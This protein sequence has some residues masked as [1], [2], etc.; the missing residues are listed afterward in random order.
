[1]AI[2][3]VLYA[4]QTTVI[5]TSNTA[6]II[7]TQTASADETIPQD[8]VLVLGKLGGVARLQKDVASCKASFKCYLVDSFIS[9]DWANCD[10]QGDKTALGG[11]VGALG[12][13]AG[14]LN[15]LEQDARAGN[16]LNHYC[17]ST[18]VAGTSANQNDG[19]QIFGICSSMGIDA[20]K[21]AFPMLDLA[22][23]GVGRLEQLNMGTGGTLSATSGGKCAIKTA[24][25][26]TS[27][28]VYLGSIIGHATTGDTVA[29]VKWSYDMPTE[30]LSRLG[31]TI[32]GQSSQIKNDN[33]VFS[34]P[35][36][37]ASMVADGQS[38]VKTP[39]EWANSGADVT[40]GAFMILEKGG[41]NA[42]TNNG[43]KVKLED[44]GT[45]VSTRSLSQ[46]VGDVGATFSVTAE[47]TKT[48][49]TVT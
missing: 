41:E 33:K 49:F 12:T 47:G 15:M 8:D 39:G 21:G 43:C 25:P 23:E 36:F 2:N 14:M 32:L 5:Q 13:S 35:P 18:G 31:G 24:V 26:L 44:A 46:N 48:L 37:K 4:T 16:V 3:R 29:S 34:K 10:V 27:K 6:W 42:S 30:T 9:E 22:F 45:N 7:P 19:F 1:M 11:N 20:S 38:L 28:D 40:K 17:D